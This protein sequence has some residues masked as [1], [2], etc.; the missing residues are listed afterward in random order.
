MYMYYEYFDLEGPWKLPNGVLQIPLFR[1]NVWLPA[2]YS[3]PKPA[4]DECERCAPDHRY[5]TKAHVPEISEHDRRMVTSATC[6][7]CG[8]CQLS[9]THSAFCNL[10]SGFC[11]RRRHPAGAVDDDSLPPK[12][13]AELSR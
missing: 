6:H 13:K 12:G 11:F 5:H 3:R 9:W 2:S 10:H 4:T 1:G 7:R 8:S